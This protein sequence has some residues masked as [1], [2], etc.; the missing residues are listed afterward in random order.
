MRLRD[1]VQVPVVVGHGGHNA[2]G[3]LSRNGGLARGVQLGEA[4]NEGLG[5]LTGHGVREAKRRRTHVHVNGAAAALVDPRVGAS[6]DGAGAMF[7]GSRA[8]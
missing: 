8:L 3:W 4:A 5:Q 1:S 2:Q 7:H 6:G